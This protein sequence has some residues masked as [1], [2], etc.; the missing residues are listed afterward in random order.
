MR[1]MGEGR[2]RGGANDGGD[3]DHREEEGRPGG[4]GQVKEFLC[5]V[6]KFWSGKVPPSVIVGRF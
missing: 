5:H 2:E 1:Q 6:L 4:G 3:K